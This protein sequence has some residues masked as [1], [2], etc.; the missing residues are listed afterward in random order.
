MPNNGV[1]PRRRRWQ[2]F[3]IIT[4]LLTIIFIGID[5]FDIVDPAFAVYCCSIL[6]CVA[7]SSIFFWL[8]YYAGRGSQLLTCIMLLFISGIWGFSLSLIARYLW[9]CKRIDE[10]KIYF[11]T[12]WW[13]YR[14]VPETLI[15]LWVLIFVC[16][17]LKYGKDKDEL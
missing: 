2:I 9:I 10:L 12:N 11:A 13:E 7:G 1:D 16:V 3:S 6:V 5:C 8:R 14:A 17:R 4:V 15:F